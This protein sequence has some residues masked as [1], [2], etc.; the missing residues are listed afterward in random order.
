[1]KLCITLKKVKKKH[2]YDMRKRKS[3]YYETIQLVNYEI[4]FYNKEGQEKT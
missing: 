2:I 3:L 4:M 1:M